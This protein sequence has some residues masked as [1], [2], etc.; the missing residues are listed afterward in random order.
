MQEAH[1]RRTTGG[2]TI[3]GVEE[4]ASTWRFS[5]FYL[6]RSRDAWLR[7]AE[8]QSSW[9]SLLVSIAV[10]A[11]VRDFEGLHSAVVGPAKQDPRVLDDWAALR[12]LTQH[13][14]EV[15]A[16]LAAA[17]NRRGSFVVLTQVSAELPR[18]DQEQLFAGGDGIGSFRVYAVPSLIVDYT[19]H[20]IIFDWFLQTYE[21]TPEYYEWQVIRI[22]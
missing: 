11:E 15:D 8:Q 19:D 7:A 20:E 13:Y 22:S 16:W 4:G 14:L 1:I 6:D 10:L 5:P 3:E 18:L 17:S 12:R 21:L 2:F 9:A